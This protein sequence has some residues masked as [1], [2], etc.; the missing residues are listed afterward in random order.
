E[1]FGKLMAE[2]SGYGFVNLREE[3]IDEEVLNLIPEI[4]ARSKGIMAFARDKDSVK[5]GMVNPDDLEARH[6][7][8][9]RIG[10][11]VLPYLIT[12][13]DFQA[14]FSRYKASLKEEFENIL[15]K[16]KDKALSREERDSLTIKIVN[17]LLQYGYQNKASDIHI[18]PR[19]KEV[20]V[21]FRIDGVL[22][23]VLSIPKDLHELISMRIKILSKMRT[24]E[25]RAAQDGKLHFSASDG[26]ADEMVDVRVSVVPVTEG[27]NVV[28]RLLSEKARSFSLESLGLSDKD[29]KKV[30]LAME[31]PH[32]M[33]LSTGP[34]GS[35]KTTTLYAVIKILNK[36]EV[37][38]AT[39]EDPVEYEIEGASQIQVNAKTNLTFARGL[40]AIVRQDPDIIMVG[41]IRDEETASI[42]VNSA[43][44]GHLVLSTL[45]TNDAAT[46]LP[47]LLDMGIEPFLVAS[48]VNVVV[49]QRLV[50]KIC[51]KC[52]ASYQLTGEE[53]KIIKSDIHLKSIFK[54][55]KIFLYKGNGC[56]VCG[57]TGYL[58]RIGIF[59]ILE[60]ADNIKNLILKRASS[61]E[62]MKLARQNGMTTML[63]DG[64]KKVFSGITTLEEVLRVIKE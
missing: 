57:N 48:T 16:L 41:E 30:M 14:V 51:V 46:T 8:E 9:K 61:G 5:L 1:H 47:R 37:N 64:A 39:I 44:T 55:Q 27:E 15:K 11:K 3:K 29:L 25:H 56:R 31:N 58:G 6:T 35:G 59:E 13:R 26:T 40:R 22:H 28:M 23:E 19:K 54:D 24:D 20:L 21:R 7:I 49:A 36:P 12:K 43:M 50:R 53:K 4:V 42:A 17:M 60:M 18:E 33:I 32:G 38:I 52:R 34:T 10:Q 63:D 2:D 45:H 62:I